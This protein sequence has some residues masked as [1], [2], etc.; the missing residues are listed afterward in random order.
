MVLRAELVVGKWCFGLSYGE[1]D[2]NASGGEADGAVREVG[3]AELKWWSL[4]V[5]WRSLAE[6]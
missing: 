2:G 4:G 3:N 1:E 5:N 6:G